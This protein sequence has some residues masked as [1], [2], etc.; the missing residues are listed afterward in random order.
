MVMVGD[1]INDVLVLVMVD[2]GMVIGIGI[3]I[4]I[5]M[6]V[7]DIMLI[8]GDLNGIVDVIGMSRFI[9]RNIK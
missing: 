6:E 1:G 2:I 7:V 4:D 8:C 9:M 5:V 3:G